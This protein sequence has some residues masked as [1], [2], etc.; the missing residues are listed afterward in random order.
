MELQDFFALLHP[1]IAIIV[2]FPLIGIVVNRALLTRQRRLQ[3]AGGEKSKIPPVVGSEHVAIGSWLSRSVV[4]V[5]LLGMAYPIFSKM[6]SND[7]LT[8]E[9]FRVFFVIAIFLLSIA[10]F[11]LL[12][13]ANVK[14]W[15]GIF[16]TFTGMGLM[17]LGFQPEIFRRDNE[18]FVSHYYYGITAALLMI[19]SV[20][21]VQDI[22]QDR[23]N[24][25][26]TAHIILNCFA[27]LLFIG[28][29]MTG[30][31]DL[32]EIP[33]HWQSQYIYQCDFTN[34]TCPQP[35]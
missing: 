13:K 18:W 32:L 9:P 28:Q 20:A 24:R 14:L 30:T 5:A 31:R 27:L 33:L 3:V 7:T 2:V 34:K 16:A 21:I 17:I 11:T 23:Q 12:F 22:Y 29:G 25:W 6:L 8:K 1:A 15:R 26:R 4:G 10:S 19:F 35:K